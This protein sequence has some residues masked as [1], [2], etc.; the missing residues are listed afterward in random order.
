MLPDNFDLYDAHERKQSEELKRRPVCSE[1][2]EPITGEHCYV[3]HGDFYCE[4]CMAGFY[5]Y[6]EDYINE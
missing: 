3:I 4:K 6:T 1:C 2:D 5:E